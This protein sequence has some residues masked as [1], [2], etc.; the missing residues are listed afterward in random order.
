MTPPLASA[1]RTATPGQLPTEA[2]S[3]RLQVRD[4]AEE[5]RQPAGG[6]EP[7]EE[8]AS[9]PATQ[10]QPASIGGG[11]QGPAQGRVL[12]QPPPGTGDE[13]MGAETPQILSTAAVQ[14]GLGRSPSLSVAPPSPGGAV[15]SSLSPTGV[16]VGLERSPSPPFTPPSPGGAAAS[17]PGSVQGAS[18][19]STPVLHVPPSTSAMVPASP[20][21]SPSPPP[22][23]PQPQPTGPPPAMQPTVRRSGR[24]AVAEDGAGVTDE[25]VMQRAMRRK[26]EL[27]LDTAEIMI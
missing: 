24:Y 17:R 10:L 14:V 26:A 22:A 13:R 27:N 4:A 6:S 19:T 20:R 5:Q 15:A 3:A 16:Q 1:E 21:P 2:V 9:R 25:D 8:L 7:A 12:Q 11:Q 18:S 23:A